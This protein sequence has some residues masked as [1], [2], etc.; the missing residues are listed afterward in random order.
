MDSTEKG[1]RERIHIGAELWSFLL[2]KLLDCSGLQICNKQHFKQQNQSNVLFYN[3]RNR[4]SKFS[5]QPG[6]QGKVYM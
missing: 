2:N 5:L 3:S 6:H 4:H 1:S